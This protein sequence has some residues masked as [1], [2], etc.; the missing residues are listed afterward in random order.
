MRNYPGKP[1]KVY[2]FGTCLADLFYPEAGMAGIKLIQQQGVKVIYPSQQS[3]CGQPAYN[4][5]FV[6]QARAVAREKLD[7][8]QQIEHGAEA[9]GPAHGVQQSDGRHQYPLNELQSTE[10]TPQMMI[11]HRIAVEL[12]TPHSQKQQPKNS[13]APR[14]FLAE[15]APDPPTY[16]QNQYIG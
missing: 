7:L 15:D 5:G 9:Q 13:I 6:K 11:G 2:Y 3:C 12:D 8:L 10:N 14:T 16:S 4:S 1:D